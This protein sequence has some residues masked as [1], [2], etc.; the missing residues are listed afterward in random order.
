LVLHLLKTNISKKQITRVRKFLRSDVTPLTSEAIDEIKSASKNISNAERIMCKKHRIYASRYKDIINNRIPLE[1]TNEW[2]KIINS[3]CIEPSPCPVT[4]L[5]SLEMKQVNE[6]EQ[7]EQMV[8]GW[9]AS[10][11]REEKNISVCSALPL[12]LSAKGVPSGAGEIETASEVLT[13][14]SDASSVSSDKTIPLKKLLQK[15]KTKVGD[16]T[17]SHI[18]GKNEIEEDFRIRY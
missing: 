5:P 7:A 16:S 2:R 17:P 4:P 6:V 1:P 3:V 14:F 11:G 9:Q 12:V 8:N 13:T 15:R 18:A 10:S